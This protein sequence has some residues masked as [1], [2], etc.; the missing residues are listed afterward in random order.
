MQTVLRLL[1]KNFFSDEE[2]WVVA[3]IFQEETA[4]AVANKLK[5]KNPEI[6]F[7]I[8]DGSIAVQ[9]NDKTIAT[10]IEEK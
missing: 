8:E 2:V 10:I 6:K 5:E 7:T 3:D 9:K 1:K 4:L